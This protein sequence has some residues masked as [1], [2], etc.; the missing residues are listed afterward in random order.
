MREGTV[1]VGS[2][3]DCSGLKNGMYL[4][5]LTDSSDNSFTLKL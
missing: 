2:W 3:I 5:S 4:L 1:S